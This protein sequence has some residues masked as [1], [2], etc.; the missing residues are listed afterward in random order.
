MIS[1]P[2]ALCAVGILAQF[3][4]NLGLAHWK[5]LKCVMGYLYTTRDLWLIFGG[6]DVEL[7]GFSNVD[8]A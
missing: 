7:E 6:V 4:Q 5:A 3:V 8:W 2:D 1:R